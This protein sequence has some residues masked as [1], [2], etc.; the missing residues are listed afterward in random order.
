MKTW[1]AFLLIAIS[2]SAVAE[3]GNVTEVTGAATIKRGSNLITVSKGTPVEMNDRVETKTGL[4]NIKFKDDTTV[5]VTE[6]SALVIDDFVYDPKTQGGKLGL[7]AAEGTVRYVSGAIAHN[8]P[9]AVNI[10]TPTAAIAVRGTDFVMSVDET[11]KSL[12]MLMPTCEDNVQM[13]N[14]KGLIC[15]SGKIDVESGGEIVHLDSPY[16]ATLVETVGNAPSAPVVVNLFG[17]PIGNN[18]HL[19]PPKTMSGTSIVAAARSAAQKT[20]DAKKE[21]SDNK[22]EK[23][24]P[25]VGDTTAQPSTAEAQINEKQSQDQMKAQADSEAEAQQAAKAIVDI[26]SFEKAT[27]VTVKNAVDE[28]PNVFAVFQNNN[29]LLNQIGW[30]YASLSQDGHNYANVALQ[31]DTQLLVFVT[32]DHVADAYNFNGNSAKAFGSITITQTYR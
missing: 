4:V 2:S 10:K 13:V 32:Q 24:G 22:D 17:T 8:N 1:V 6:H 15:G 30:G 18:L 20:G 23:Q 11:G 5:K 27:G 14:L 7:K 25:S 12:V 9:N 3:I 28:D 16:Q 26:A 19:S 21:S 29:P 31:P